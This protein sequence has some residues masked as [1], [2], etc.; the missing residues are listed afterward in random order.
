MQDLANFVLR[1]GAA[2]VPVSLPMEGDMTRAPRVSSGR[3]FVSYGLAATDTQT[4]A[5]FVG[6]EGAVLTNIRDPGREVS[7]LRVL[8]VDPRLSILV[9]EELAR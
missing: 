3:S 1:V 6:K 5:Q 7:R 8:K 4:A 9:G 2:E